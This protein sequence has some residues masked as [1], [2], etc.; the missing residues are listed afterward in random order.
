MALVHHVVE[1]CALPQGTAHG[2]VTLLLTARAR[3]RIRGVLLDRD[4]AW[5][6]HRCCPEGLPEKALNSCGLTPRTPQTIAGLAH[7]IHGSV[8]IIPD[9]SG[10]SSKMLRY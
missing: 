9:P 2:E 5:G 3:W 8:E 7:G 10:F 4:D 6:G 1:V